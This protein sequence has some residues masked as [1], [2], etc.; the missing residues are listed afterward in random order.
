LSI[1]VMVISIISYNEGK[2]L[3]KFAR[4]IV[5]NYIS[6]KELRNYPNVTKI[7]AGAFV[8]LFRYND[9][10]HLELRGCIGFPY[11]TGYLSHN[12]MEAS[13]AAATRDPR[14]NA[15]TVSELSEV[16]FEVS[17]LTNPSEIVVNNPEDYLGSIKIGNDGLIL[18]WEYGS[19]LLLP[20]VPVD[21]NWNVKEYLTHLCGK[22]GGPPDLWRSPNTKLYKF[23]ALV[24]KEVQPNGDIIKV[25]FDT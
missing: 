14:F 11:P 13:I 4:Q 12:I 1:I 9:L 23:Q 10:G 24:F 20:Q 25:N 2:E 16:I 17:I 6:K 19:G 22:A 15:L 8:S 5:D 18:H 3:V 7:K 21:Y